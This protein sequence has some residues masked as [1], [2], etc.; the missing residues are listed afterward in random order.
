MPRY[1]LFGDTVN[2]ASR[3]ESNGKPGQ[4]H[5]STDTMRFLTQVIGGYKT[6]PRGEVIVKV[7]VTRDANR[8]SGKD[9]SA[10]SFPTAY[11]C[12]PELCKCLSTTY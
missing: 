7:S 5:I 8:L 6:E 12:G 10:C 3:I 11:T 9:N 2:T 4:I 1:C